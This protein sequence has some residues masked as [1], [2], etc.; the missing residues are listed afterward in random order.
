[1]QPWQFMMRYWMISIKRI[2]ART[3]TVMRMERGV[4]RRIEMIPFD[5]GHLTLK[6]ING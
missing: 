4:R 6:E 2:L 1:M 3:G 5:D